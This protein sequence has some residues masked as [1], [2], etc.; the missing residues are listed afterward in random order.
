M[1][2]Y[3]EHISNTPTDDATLDAQ[4]PFSL[5][6]PGRSE[7]GPSEKRQRV[8][9]ELLKGELRTRASEGASESERGR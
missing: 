7:K 8:S 2:K 3:R 1:L 4:Y 5:S 9:G 6:L